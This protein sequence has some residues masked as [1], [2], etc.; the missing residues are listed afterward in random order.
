MKYYYHIIKMLELLM[1]DEI[2]HESPVPAGR[3]PG[4]GGI[5]LAFA[6]GQENPCLVPSVN[7]A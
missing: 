3:E 1:Q 4:P 2:G 6:A 5:L 7:D